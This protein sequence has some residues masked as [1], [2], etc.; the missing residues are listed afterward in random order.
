MLARG[1]PQALVALLLGT[2][3]SP[4]PD[5]SGGDCT[6]WSLVWY[7]HAMSEEHYVT[8]QLLAGLPV[9]PPVLSR[10]LR[11]IAEAALRSGDPAAAAAAVHGAA[12]QPAFPA[13]PWRGPP[14]QLQAAMVQAAA[15]VA[16]GMQDCTIAVTRLRMSPKCA[17]SARLAE[18]C[19][20][21]GLRCVFVVLGEEGDGCGAC[22]AF[23]KAAQLV[24]RNYHNQDCATLGSRVLT[25]PMGL[26]RPLPEGLRRGGLP[27]SARRWAWSFA[28]QHETRPRTQVARFF[29]RRF[30]GQQ[31]HR[32]RLVYPGE[33]PEYMA[34]LCDSKFALCPRGN[35]EDTWRLHEALHCGAIPVVTD[36][37]EY[38]PRYMPESLTRHFV[39]AAADLRDGSLEAVVAEI[40]RLLQSPEELLRKQQL[41]LK[42]HAD[43]GQEWSRSVLQGVG[44]VATHRAQAPRS[45]SGEL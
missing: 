1:A 5:A 15:D 6:E 40:E 16:A 26:A 44:A 29:Q 45:A 22:Q 21:R 24:I 3:G 8:S 7:T 17:A 18:A 38:F 36:G 42:A 25:V 27:A 2:S 9:R 13:A 41:L 20:S 32:F 23:Y 12:P 43:F 10:P 34:T 4:A 31:E 28:S 11:T 14:K 33:D 30:Q 39:T 37:G 19:Q 35:V